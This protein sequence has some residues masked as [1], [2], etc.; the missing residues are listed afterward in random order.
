MNPGSDD[1]GFAA[2]CR[3]VC[4]TLGLRLEAYRGKQL[5]RR[6]GFFRRRHR[7]ADNAELARRLR[8]DGELQ[9]AFADFL[10]INVT[11][12]F[13]NPERFEALRLRHLPTLLRQRSPLRV[14]SAGCSNGAELYSVAMLLAELTPGVGHELLGTDIDEGSLNQARKGVYAAQAMKTVP[15]S[16]RRYFTERGDGSFVI[17]RRLRQQ[18]RFE[19]HDLLRDAYPSDQ[20]LVLCRNVAI[21]FTEESKA[22]LHGQL[23]ESLRPGGILVIGATESIFRARS[24]GLRYL[25]PGFYERDISNNE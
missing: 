1:Q 18:A 6:L 2:L 10:T 20:D 23:A 9:Q 16:F 3:V 7:I 11:E 15:P 19:Y 21:Y 4:D 14:W 8:G 22:R 13:R 25:K 12:F 24:H 5:E 17:D